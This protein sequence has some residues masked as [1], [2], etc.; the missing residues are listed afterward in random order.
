MTVLSPNGIINV[1]N[2]RVFWFIEWGEG[3]LKGRYTE[4]KGEEC[5]FTSADD[6]NLLCTISINLLAVP[7][8]TLLTILS[9]LRI[10]LSSLSLISAIRDRGRCAGDSPNKVSRPG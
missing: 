10:H 2:E 8:V 3:G 5:G 4:N 6:D 7:N 9:T 1:T